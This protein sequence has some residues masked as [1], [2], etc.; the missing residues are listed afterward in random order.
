MPANANIAKLGATPIYSNLSPKIFSDSDSGA[1]D[2]GTLPE[3]GTINATI[4]LSFSLE[5]LYGTQALISKDVD[6]S[7]KGEFTVWVK[8]GVLMV[9]VADGSETRTLKVPNLI[10]DDGQTYHL[11]V[12]T[13]KDG[14]MIWLDGQL[15]AA[16]PDIKVGLKGNDESLVIGGTRAWTSADSDAHSL[17]DGTIGDVMVFNKQ[18]DNWQIVKLA[19]AVDPG[20]GNAADMALDMAKLAPAFEQLHHGS[21][22]FKAILSLCQAQIIHIFSC[23]SGE[24]Q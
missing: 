8:D 19:G 1:I 17:V 21:D 22:T 6:G 18:L 7:G 3:I 24:G 13:G 16:E 20:M 9:S 15:A 10:L 12:S 2:L 23:I 5:R 4:S 11:A 14:L